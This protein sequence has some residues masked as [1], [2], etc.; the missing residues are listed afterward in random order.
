MLPWP[1]ITKF[2]GSMPI[3]S[4]SETPALNLPLALT[5][6]IVAYWFHPNTNQLEYVYPVDEV[7]SLS[8]LIRIHKVRLKRKKS[9]QL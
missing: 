4:L 2:F 9:Q 8:F 5:I 3:F 1:V 6:L 7:C